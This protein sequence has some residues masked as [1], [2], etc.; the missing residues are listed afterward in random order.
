M[1]EEK[2]GKNPGKTKPPTTDADGKAATA[3]KK[4]KKSKGGKGKLIAI[5]ATLA[6]VLIGGGVTAFFL[7]SGSEK[8]KG[9][10]QAAVALPP[11]PPDPG[12][13][14]TY[15]FPKVLA[16]LKTGECRSNFLSARFMV[17]VGKNYTKDL[18]AKQDKIVEGVMLHL[19]SL[20]RKDLVGKEGS[21][22]MRADL[23]SIINNI[24]KPAKVE[25]IV[26]KEFIL[27]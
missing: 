27:Q 13:V 18:Q 2:P 12:P 22:R 25:G 4:K 11:P 23:I 16:D 1:A 17:E 24:A 20:E 15:D 3:P 8:D 10:Q 26:F 5:A 7:L 19:R 21:D 14:T 9:V 6:V